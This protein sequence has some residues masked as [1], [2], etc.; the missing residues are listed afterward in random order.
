VDPWVRQMDRIRHALRSLD[1]EAAL[2]E[3]PRTLAL[4]VKEQLGD[5]A[6]GLTELLNTLDRQ[7]Y[8]RQAVRRP[9]SSLTRR[10]VSTAR[11]LRRS[12]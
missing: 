8:G 3:P 2:H 9:D 7:R 11:T 5:A 6:Q 4:R 1:V 12:R 10:F